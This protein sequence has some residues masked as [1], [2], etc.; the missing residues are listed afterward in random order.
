MIAEFKTQDGQTWL[1]DTK[2]MKYYLLTSLRGANGNAGILAEG[3]L[4]RMGQTP[5]LAF[6]GR[7]PDSEPGN[8]LCVVRLA[9]EIDGPV[10]VVAIQAN[11]ALK[12]F[13]LAPPIQNI[14]YLVSS[15]LIEAT[16]VGQ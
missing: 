9:A 10:L 6:S 7:G 2:A 12:D 11:V 15:D 16:A 1:I 5:F 8:G 13:M 3:V 14:T 4:E